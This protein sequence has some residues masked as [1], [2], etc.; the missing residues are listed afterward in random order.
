MSPTQ[1]IARD[2]DN[3]GWMDA[4]LYQILCLTLFLILGVISRDWTISTPHIG[5][6]IIACLSAQMFGTWRSGAIGPASGPDST[7]ASPTIVTLA[8]NLQRLLSGWPSAL[9]TS[10]GL[11]L[12]LRSEHWTTLVLASIAAIGSK[13]LLR[14][15]GK[16][17]FN[18]ANFGII[19]A[20]LVTPDAWV[21]PGQWGNEQWYALLFLV[22]GGFVLKQVGR[23]DTSIAFLIT[24]AGLEAIRNGW[25]GWTWDVWL[26][27]FSSGSLWLFALFMIT[28]PRTIPD[29]RPARLVWAG[30]IAL[31]TFVLRNV[32]F[33]STAPFWALFV[34]APLSVL[35]DRLVPADRFN[36]A[37]TV[38]N[39]MS[40]SPLPSR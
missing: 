33:I 3:I 32:W 30:A 8:A 24:D 38:S 12:L 27:Q 34:L 1:W 6:I 5:W 18:P 39:D 37:E 36:W 16:H 19:T 14:H 25:L 10:L 31:L 9:I 26:H 11:S 23:W 4:R 22:T 17:L 13:F 35:L 20:L 40:C 7:P 28:D 2:M 15:N 21:S 29:A